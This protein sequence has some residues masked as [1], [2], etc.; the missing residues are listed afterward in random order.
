MKA[1][2][3]RA[4]TL[5]LPFWVVALIGLVSLQKEGWQ[6]RDQGLCLPNVS[7]QNGMKLSIC[8]LGGSQQCLYMIMLAR[9]FCLDKNIMVPYNIY[10]IY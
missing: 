9:I 1:Y 4:T 7:G 3:D 2:G 5:Q 8:V 10:I 6:L